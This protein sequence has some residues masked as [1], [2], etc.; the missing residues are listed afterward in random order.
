MSN[1]VSAKHCNTCNKDYKADRGY[2]HRDGTCLQE[3]TKSAE[4]VIENIYSAKRKVV[5]PAV[6]DVIKRELSE[7]E[8]KVL[9]LKSW[10]SEIEAS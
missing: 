9:S 5:P 2:K 4:R 1:E 10:L 6:V 8:A 3:N 7:A